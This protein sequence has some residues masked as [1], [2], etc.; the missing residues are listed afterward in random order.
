[1][2]DLTIIPHPI[3]RSCRRPSTLQRYGI[4]ILQVS[5]I[6]TRRQV[7]Y[8]G[9]ITRRGPSSARRS[10]GI[11]RYRCPHPL[12]PGTLGGFCTTVLLRRR[13]ALKVYGVE[14]TS[15]SLI[16]T[17][18]CQASIPAPKLYLYPVNAT[19]NDDGDV[20]RQKTRLVS[21]PLFW[22]LSYFLYLVCGKYDQGV[23]ISRLGLRATT[24]TFL[25]DNCREAQT[26]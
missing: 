18:S 12:P 16:C 19:P 23:S 8:D 26:L 21:F 17:V 9:K 5:I 24:S 11:C 13:P 20:L 14:S 10:R 6:N 1:M 15:F 7:R 22:A 2:N 25:A 4:L 3:S